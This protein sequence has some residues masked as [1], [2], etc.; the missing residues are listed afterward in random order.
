M[1]GSRAVEPEVMM[2]PV[3][4]VS[5]LPIAAGA[6]VCEGAADELQAETTIAAATANAPMHRNLVNNLF[7]S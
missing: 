7:A 2:L 3:T 1:S 5:P 4:H 6:S